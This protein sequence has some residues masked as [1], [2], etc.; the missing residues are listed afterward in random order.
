MAAVAVGAVQPWCS[1]DCPC[2]PE[3][4]PRPGRARQASFL[5]AGPLAIAS[6]LQAASAIS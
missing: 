6:V 2:A 5:A 3:A 4:L 1:A